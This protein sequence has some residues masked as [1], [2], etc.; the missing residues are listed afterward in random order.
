MSFGAGFGAGLAIGLGIGRASAGVDCRKRLRV[1]GDL[2]SVEVRD[3]NG[4]S[5]DYEVLVDVASASS[6]GDGAQS[7]RLL[8]SGIAMLAML[9]IA[10][11]AIYLFQ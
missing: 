1:F 4:N 2:Y 10:G 9:S 5:I 11:I 3:E 6:L 8:F 7:R